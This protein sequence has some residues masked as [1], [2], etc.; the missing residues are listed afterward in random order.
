MVL[1]ICNGLLL[2]A[3]IPVTFE[4]CNLEY[5]GKFTRLQMWGHYILSVTFDLFICIDKVALSGAKWYTPKFDSLE[6]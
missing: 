6:C 1:Y 4:L 5:T 2:Y 3:V